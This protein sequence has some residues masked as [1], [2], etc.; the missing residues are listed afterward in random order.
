MGTSTKIFGAALGLSLLA[1][2][3]LGASDEDMAVQAAIKARQAQMD[4]YAYNLGILGAMAKGDVEYNADIAG[5]AAS[6]IVTLTSLDQSTLWPEGSDSMA[7]ETRALPAI[8]DNFPDVM[9]K[10]QA[11][12]E[13]AVA[14][15][16]AAGTG[17]DG[18]RAAIGPLGGACGACHK[19]YRAPE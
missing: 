7:A 9:T 18:L 13:A 17:I 2:A 14:M 16:A 6:N 1:G 8:W 11:L 4:L 19:V 5:G 15:E 12:V 3:A 10:S